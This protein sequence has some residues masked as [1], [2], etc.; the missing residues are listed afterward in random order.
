MKFDGFTPESG[1]MT[2]S[3]EG[4]GRF[5]AKVIATRYSSLPDKGDN[6]L[7][8]GETDKQMQIVKPGESECL[9]PDD[10]DLDSSG[11]A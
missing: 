4:D 7:A 1:E 5:V 8:T 9:T 11:R 10:A 3:A 6:F 2:T